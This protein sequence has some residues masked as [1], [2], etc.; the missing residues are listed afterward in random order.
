MKTPT[1]LLFGV[2]TTGT[3]SLTITASGQLP[4]QVPDL[5][6]CTSGQDVPIPCSNNQWVATLGAGDH[7]VRLPAP[8]DT[9]LDGPLTFTLSDP[10]TI[11]AAANSS[12]AP[13]MSWT[14]TT[15]MSSDPKNPWPPPATGSA[16]LAD[17][18]LLVSRLTTAGAQVDPLRG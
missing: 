9:S 4:Q 16:P 14:A 13:L 12:G 10:A 3:V 15:G 7:V 17:S 8:Y 18:S 6:I 2:R 1:R 11:V 5:R